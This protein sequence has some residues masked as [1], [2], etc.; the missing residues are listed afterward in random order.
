MLLYWTSRIRIQWTSKIHTL[1]GEKT[2]CI[3]NSLSNL[4]TLKDDNKNQIQK[5]HFLPRSQENCRKPLGKPAT[6]TQQYKDENFPLKELSTLIN[7]L[8]NIIETLKS[9]KDT[10]LTLSTQMKQYLDPQGKSSYPFKNRT[11]TKTQNHCLVYHFELEIP[12]QQFI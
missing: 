2:L 8:K 10:Q 3:F 9:K 5:K 7:A 6:K 11:K 12:F 4:A 1:C